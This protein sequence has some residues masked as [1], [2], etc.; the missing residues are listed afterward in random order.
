MFNGNSL[1][2]FKSSK[3]KADVFKIV[4]EELES[5]GT[6]SITSSG[7]I[8]IN[9][10]RFNGF[11]FKTNIEGRISERDGRFS[12]HLDYQAKPE[13]IAWIIAICFFPIGAA[14]LILPNNAKEN[15]Q[16]KADLTFSEIKSILEER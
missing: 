10:S 6:V 12:I 5:M 7:G 4:E 14:I 16:R 13:I 1:V 11:G 2:S 15:M 9:G 3:S 8:T